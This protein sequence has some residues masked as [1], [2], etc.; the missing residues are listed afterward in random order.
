MRVI[1][2]NVQGALDREFGRVCR[3]MLAD[4]KPDIFIVIEPRC[5]GTRARTSIRKLG[6]TFHIISEVQGF[7]GGI[8]ILWNKPGI[9]MRTL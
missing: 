3:L 4:N 5:S 6:F 2:W 7:A 9:N 8:W 1:S